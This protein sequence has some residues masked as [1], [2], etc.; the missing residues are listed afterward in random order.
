MGHGRGRNLVVRVEHRRVAAEQV[1]AEQLRVQISGF[2]Y[3]VPHVG[4]QFAELRGCSVVKGGP[5]AE[6]EFQS[7]AGED[8]GAQRRFLFLGGV[9]ECVVEVPSGVV[10]PGY[11]RYDAVFYCRLG[12]FDQPEKGGLGYLRHSFTGCC[13]GHHSYG[14]SN[15]K[16]LHELASKPYW[17]TVLKRTSN[18]MEGEP[19]FNILGFIMCVSAT[20]A[21]AFKSVLQDIL[22]S[23]EGEKLNSMNLLLYMA[24]IAVVVLVPATILM[25]DNVVEITLNI[26][27]KDTKMLWYLLFNSFLAYFVNLTNFLVT[28]Y[29]SALTLQVLGNAKGALAVAVSILI[30]KNPITTIGMVGYG[31]TVLGVV[32]YTEAKKRYS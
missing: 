13:G 20:A 12:V 31:L 11:R 2:P 19:S 7:P 27:R 18:M 23:S 4:L 1:F 32:V 9:W 14:D 21:R 10:Y 17:I 3:T 16:L 6:R 30:F 15:A 5:S 22:L 24:P 26:A 28:K 29:T 8:R 25:E